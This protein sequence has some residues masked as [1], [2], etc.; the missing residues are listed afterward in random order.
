MFQNWKEKKALYKRIFIITLPLLIQNLMASAVNSADVVMLNFVGQ[1]AVSA[2][3]L[4]T[5]YGMVAFMVF[6]GI[7][8]GVTILSAQYWGKGDLDA[9]HKVEGIGMRYSLG[10]ASVFF[11]G[12]MFAPEFMM[13]VLTDDA[14]LIELG[15]R[16]LRLVGPC[17]LMWAITEVFLATLR[18]A[19]RVAICTVIDSIALGTNCCLN[20]CFI[21]GL[22]GFPQLGIEGVAIATTFSRLLAMAI[23]IAVSMKSKN[24]KLV[25]KPIFQKHRLLHKDFIKMALPAVGNDLSWSS[26]FFMYSVI[27]G[28]LGDDVVAANAIASVVRD[29][30][31]VMCYAIGSAAG[32]IIGQVLG[33]NKLDEAKQ[34]G[35]TMLY[36]SIFAGILGG[37]FSLAVTP[38]TLNFARVSQQA[39]GYLKFMMFVNIYYIT[40]SAVNTTLIAGVFRAGGDTKFGLICDT[41]D[42]WGYAVP[43]G[44]IAAFVLKLPVEWVYFLLCT[45]EFV[46]WPWVLKRFYSY[47]WVKNITRENLD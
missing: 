47:K 2:S 32:I 45:D 26:A 41:I 24:V 7:G 20:A 11:I 4:A 22:F 46:K 34:I 9:V 40:G 3:S 13:R 36:A 31:S 18:S 6:F 14:N 44:F 21:F 1:E 12:C 25:F 33:E 39:L 15:S 28:H 38:F 5:K 17:Y 19:G 10:I 37:L 29:L 27:L 8:T 42:M 30:G 23:C 43:L 16:Y 35:K